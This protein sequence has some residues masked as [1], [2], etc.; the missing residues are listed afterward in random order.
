MLFGHGNAPKALMQNRSAGRPLSDVI[1][2]CKIFPPNLWGFTGYTGC[3]NLWGSP[4]PLCCHH[5]PTLVGEGSAFAAPAYSE[6]EMGFRAGVRRIPP[7]RT[8]VRLLTKKVVAHEM[9]FENQ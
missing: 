7:S 9:R 5:E 8:T 6:T 1:W 3:G 2:R 4:S